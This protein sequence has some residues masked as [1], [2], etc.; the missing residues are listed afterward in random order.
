LESDVTTEAIAEG[1]HIE[2]SSVD[3]AAQ[4][5]TPA[6]L[7]FVAG[8]QRR[9]GPVR[10]QLLEERR[11]RREQVRQTGRLEFRSDTADI[12]AGEWSVAPQAADL[13]DR[14]VEITGPTDRKMAI[15]ALNS[16]AKI[17]LADLE[18]ANTPRWDNVIA[19]QTCLFDAIRRTL[20]FTSPDKQ[21]E[22][23][24]DA[25]LATIVMRPRGWHMEERHLLVDGVPV[26]AGLVDFGLYFFHNAQELLDRG[27]GPYFYLPKTESYLEARLW[28]DI[29]TFAEESLAI[30]TG[31]VR[32]TVLIETIYAA[33]EMEEILYEL[34]SHA[35]GLNAGRWD[36]LF[37]IIKTFRDQGSAFVLPDRNQIT[38][39]APMMRAYTEL[40]VTTCHRRG[41]MAI[42]G[43]SAFIPNRRDSEANELALTKVRQDKQRECDDGFDG[44]WVAHPDLVP[45]CR[46]VFD[47]G[48]AGAV[49][50]M[51]R[52]H[53]RL[54]VTAAQL[55]DV[56]SIPATKTMAGLRNNVAVSLRYIGEWLNGVGAVAIFN[57]MEDAATAEIA[58]SQIW[59]WL[60]NEVVLDT[61]YQ[62][63]K[64]LI[65]TILAEELD[66][67][68]AE[69]GDPGGYYE[70]AA[71]LLSSLAFEP[72]YADFLTTAAYG[73]IA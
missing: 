71:E 48:L 4:I 35:A 45:I 70:R 5:L 38:M 50:Q 58:R 51:G 17:W 20:T 9:F 12:R 42:G 27:S 18:D 65:M 59:Q 56:A 44:S 68:R 72:E 39:T 8:L 21:Y 2:P 30:K 60:H 15:N 14:R 67:V 31:A 64:E 13:L 55:L 36:Y 69:V 25:P 62:V 46:D 52:R 73:Q 29:F 41:A 43:M 28:N 10:D 26:T 37:S 11:R 54:H 24:R 3:R 53:E 6:A 32:A 57:L 1:I 66:T 7:D 19:G 33:F 47:A 61:G 23:R 16:G 63:T 22:L 34:R 49:N 40:L